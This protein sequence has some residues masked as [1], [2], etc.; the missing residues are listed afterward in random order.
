MISDDGRY[1]I[2]QNGEIYNYIEL[3]GIKSYGISFDLKPIQKF[4]CKVIFIGVKNAL[5]DLM[6]CGLLSSMTQK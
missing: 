5:I 1:I 2:V 4:C 3:R 6:V